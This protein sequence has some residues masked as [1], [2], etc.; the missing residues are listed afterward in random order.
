V[1]LQTL[2]MDCLRYFGD[3]SGCLNTIL[4][5]AVPCSLTTWK[6]RSNA[7]PFLLSMTGNEPCLPRQGNVM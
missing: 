7:C 5:Y 4:A 3:S 2:S 1:C 6:L